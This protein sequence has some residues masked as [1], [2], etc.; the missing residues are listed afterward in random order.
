MARQYLD[1]T[2]LYAIM[3]VLELIRKAQ[4]V[5]TRNAESETDTHE[6]DSIDEVT[7][8]DAAVDP[9]AIRRAQIQ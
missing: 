2:P 7:I 9:T 1:S 4:N 5:Q 8:F 6:E 3:V